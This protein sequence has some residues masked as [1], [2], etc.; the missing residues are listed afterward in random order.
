MNSII[1]QRLPDERLL[2]RNRLAAASVEAVSVRRQ[3]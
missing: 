2:L 3:S 1:R